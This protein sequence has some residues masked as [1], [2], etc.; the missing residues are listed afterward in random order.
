METSIQPVCVVGI[1]NEYRRD[2]GVGIFIARSLRKRQMP[3][4]A[5]QEHQR[6]ATGLIEQ[7]RDFKT[8]IL[9][10]AVSSGAAP[11]TIHR[12]V[13]PPDELPKSIFYASTH[14]FG[15]ADCLELA[16]TLNQLPSR[17]VVYGIEGRDFQMGVGISKEV[18]L[19]SQKV[20]DDI[21][22]E[23]DDLLKTPFNTGDSSCTRCP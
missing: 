18:L 16:R 5:I 13:I 21:Q 14:T 23:I 19:S 11:G 2:D 4:A 20:I 15:I 9:V 7:W 8:V 12:F 10:D 6:E 1:G 17:V 22:E 3:N